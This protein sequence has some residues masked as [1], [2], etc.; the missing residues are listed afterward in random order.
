MNN[1]YSISLHKSKSPNYQGGDRQRE[2]EQKDEKQQL[3]SAKRKDTGITVMSK[4]KGKNIH[5]L[6]PAKEDLLI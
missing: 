6:I 5:N 1:K 3:M 4:Y 2:L